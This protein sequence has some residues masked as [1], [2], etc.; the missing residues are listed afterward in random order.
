MNVA[1]IIRRKG[2]KVITIRPDETVQVLLE[3]LAEH[4]FGALV[5]SSDGSSVEGI[6]SERD[7]VRHMAS[8]GA[9]VLE[10]PASSIMTAAVKTCVATDTVE[11]LMD[12]MTEH[13]IRHLPVE[14]DGAL[15]GMISIGDVVKCRVSELEDDKGHLENYIK[16]SW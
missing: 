1:E 2:N 13:R 15:A 3:R 14:I 7:V 6:V 8:D 9:A 16:Q 5:V 4:G 11:A 12:K 10:Q